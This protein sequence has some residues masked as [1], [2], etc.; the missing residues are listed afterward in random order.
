MRRSPRHVAFP[1]VTRRAVAASAVALLAALAGGCAWPGVYD[2]AAGFRRAQCD[3][4]IEPD[5]HAECLRRADAPDPRKD[6][7]RDAKQ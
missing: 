1:A 2:A 3:R 4:I 6:G 5:R 7:Q